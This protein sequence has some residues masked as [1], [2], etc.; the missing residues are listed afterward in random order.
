MISERILKNLVRNLIGFQTNSQGFDNDVNGFSNKIQR[1]WWELWLIFEIRK[2]DF[3]MNLIDFCRLW[4]GMHMILTW[5]LED[6]AMNL[7]DF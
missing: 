4:R 5:I 2:Q 7:I 6:A 3:V 1:N